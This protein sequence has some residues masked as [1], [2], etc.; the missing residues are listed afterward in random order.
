[1]LFIGILILII[2]FGFLLYFFLRMQKMRKNIKE[3]EE[4]VEKMVEESAVQS[5]LDPES[6]KRLLLQNKIPDW[7]DF[8]E[9]NRDIFKNF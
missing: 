9:S 3:M 7:K 6:V 2:Q 5:H 8:L 1:M 4:I